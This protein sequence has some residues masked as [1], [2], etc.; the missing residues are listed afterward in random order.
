MARIPLE[1]RETIILYNDADD[2]ANIYTHDK[3]LQSHIQKELGVK[4]WRTQG[5]AK[6]Y[7]IP[8]KWLRWPRK[9]S[10]KRIEAGRQRFKKLGEDHPLK[11]SKRSSK[12]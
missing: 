11:S 8:K 2:T 9:P 5:L 1:E 4:A 3:S 10:V 12:A 6:D 7:E